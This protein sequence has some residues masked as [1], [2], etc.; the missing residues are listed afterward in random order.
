LVEEDMAMMD[1]EQYGR[2]LRRID[3]IAYVG[4]GLLTGVGMVVMILVFF[5]LGGLGQ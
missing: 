1:Y 4:L 3:L 5:I 2:R